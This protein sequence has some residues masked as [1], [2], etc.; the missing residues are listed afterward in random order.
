M[1]NSLS[2]IRNVEARREKIPIISD[3]K[4]SEE[5]GEHSLLRSYACCEL[6][7]LEFLLSGG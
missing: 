5:R 1:T 3:V 7:L 2:F 4:M 6:L